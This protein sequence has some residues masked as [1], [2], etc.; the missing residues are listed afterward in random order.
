MKKSTDLLEE[1]AQSYFACMGAFAAK[2]ATFDREALR[3]VWEVDDP[4]KWIRLF[5]QRGLLEYLPDSQRYQMHALL[6][7]HA[8]SLC[9]PT[10]L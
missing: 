8:R 6:A 1:P 7:A 3:S 9:E 2:P 4:D 5:V 10:D